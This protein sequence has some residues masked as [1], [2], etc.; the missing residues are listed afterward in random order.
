MVIAVRRIVVCIA[1]EL[2][3]PLNE[4]KYT[5]IYPY[6]GL[7]ILYVHYRN[8][9]ISDWNKLNQKLEL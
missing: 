4:D 2:K 1:T 6:I 3:K 7:R 5:I 8:P 9:W